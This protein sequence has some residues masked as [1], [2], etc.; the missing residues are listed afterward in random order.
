MSSVKL[1]SKTVSFDS[2]EQ[3]YRGFIAPSFKVIVS[4]KDIVKEGMAIESVTIQT[5]TSKIADTVSFSVTNAY[6]L[7][8]RDLKWADL[9]QPGNSV[10]VSIG[11]T[12]ILTP[13]FFGYISNTEFNFS[14]GQAPVISVTA[15]DISFFMMRSGEPQIWSNKTIPD[16]VE[17]LGRKYGL[18]EF[19]IEKDTQVY[20]TLMKNT[21][22]DHKFIKNLADKLHYEFFVVGKKLYFRPYMN[23]RTPVMT[24][25]WGKQL[26]SF[27]LEHD[28]ADQVT[29]VIVK[30]NIR[31]SKD[32]VYG[33]ASTV[34]KLGKN[35][36]T[37]GDLL[38]KIGTFIQ[39]IQEQVDD[40]AE[41]KE[42]AE[43]KMEEISMKLVSASA[44]CIGLPEIRAGR[45]I[46]IGGLGKRLNTLYYIESATHT[47]GSSGYQTSFKLKGNAV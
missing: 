13:L 45:Y 14:S 2:L 11:Y 37:G 25:E 20:P 21:E 36:L 39:V 22:T 7:I 40:E 26:M 47:V 31:K 38:K 30:G 4:N 6:D 24:L 19:D 9:L 10:E 27:K 33:E 41:A 34:R 12:D 23:N 44:S 18:T 32:I 8:K 42:L 1:D 35:S 16:I 28:I 17:E 15:M 43:A 3:H 5:S 46:E 29:K